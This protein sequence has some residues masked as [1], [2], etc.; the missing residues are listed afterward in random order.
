[1]IAAGSWVRDRDYAMLVEI[2]SNPVVIWSCR[3]S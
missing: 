2:Y 3:R 1:M